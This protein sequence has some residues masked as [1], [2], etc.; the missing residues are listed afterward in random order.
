MKNLI[1]TLIIFGV[2][3]FPSTV[4][5][6]DPLWRYETPGAVLAIETTEDTVAIG[7]KGGVISVF[8]ITGI[9]KW[10]FRTGG[11]VGSISI[12]GD[13]LAVG[14]ADSSIYIFDS[15]TGQLRWTAYIGEFPKVAVSE[16]TIAVGTYDNELFV[17]NKDNGKV[18]WNA[19]GKDKIENIFLIEISKNTLIAATGDIDSKPKRGY[20]RTYDMTTGRR[21]W[22]YKIDGWAYTLAVS[23]DTIITGSWKEKMGTGEVYAL[24]RDGNLRWKLSEFGVFSGLEEI[25][26][27]A[28]SGDSVA[29]GEFGYDEGKVYLV[30]KETGEVKWSEYI[31]D[32]FLDIES[33][34]SVQWIA[35]TEGSV[36]VGSRDNKVYV[37]EKETGC[38]RWSYKARNDIHTVAVSGDK[39]IAGSMDRNVYVFNEGEIGSA[40]WCKKQMDEGTLKNIEIAGIIAAVL[41]FIFVVMVFTGRI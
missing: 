8:S 22:E 12:F 35:L 3:L 14:S 6:Q 23:D 5:A 38:E 25:S 31:R 19:S 4:I 18:I 2:L 28:V 16:Y 37:Y 11:D 40:P 20:I 13:T 30:D 39:V 17:L 34:F 9:L 10:K 32:P 1:I 33:P 15:D 36:I 7:S 26:S 24:D 29:F 21:M 27:V 41:G